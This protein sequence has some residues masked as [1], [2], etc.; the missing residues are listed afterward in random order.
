M[1]VLFAREV[2]KN[3]PAL[4]SNDLLVALTLDRS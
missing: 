2:Q 4:V 1:P 3:I